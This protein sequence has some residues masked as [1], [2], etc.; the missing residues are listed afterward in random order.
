[1]SF[2]VYQD[3]N[4]LDEFSFI[5]GSMFSL[6]YTVYAEDGVNLID[7]SAATVKVLFC[8]YGQTDYI[9][10]NVD[11]V[12]TGEGT[13]RVDL[14]PDDTRLLSGKYT[15]QPVIYAFDGTEYRPAQGTCL[16]KPAIPDV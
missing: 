16:I 12:V 6:Y 4:S 7:L 11:G 3:V 10:L 13:F 15:Q 8:P 14:L 1:M 9:V 5:A 2:T